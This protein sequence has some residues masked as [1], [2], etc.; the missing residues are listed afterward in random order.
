MLHLKL[1]I[2]ILNQVF[3]YVLK[4]I[5]EKALEEVYQDLIYTRHLNNCS[6]SLEK[7][8]GHAMAIG[9]TIKKDKLEEFKKEFEKIA[10]E[11]NI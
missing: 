11:N 8:G 2:C 9:I 3:Y 10:E 1:Q 4:M 7:F 5:L 6:D